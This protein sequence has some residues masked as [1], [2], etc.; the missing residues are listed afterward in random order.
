MLVVLAMILMVAVKGGGG[1]AGIR[2][3]FL[4]SASKVKSVARCHSGLV[5]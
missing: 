1:T 3:V 4:K 5:A 2:L